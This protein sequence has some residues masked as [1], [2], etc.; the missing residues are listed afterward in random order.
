MA[1]RVKTFIQIASDMLAH[2]RA[3]QRRISDFNVGS[4][5][6]VMLEAPAAEID[7]LYQSYTRGLI[8][9]IPVAIYRSFDFELQEAVS[10]SGLVRFSAV[11]GHS[12]PVVIR[13]GFLVAAGG[14]Q[15][16]VAAEAVIPV[17][18]LTVDV[19]VV[20]RTK[21]VE[22][23]A[24][25]DTITSLVSS[26]VDLQGVTN[27][28]ALSN[29]RGMETDEERKLRF[30]EYVR[31]LARGTP[32]SCVYAARQARLVDSST[33]FIL[34]R[35]TRAE[36]QETPGHTD[37][38]IHNGAGNTSDALLKRATDL[39][40]GG[41]SDP[42]TGLPVAGYDAVGARLD[43]LK[44]AEIPV[45]ATLQVQVPTAARTEAMRAKIIA[46]VSGAIRAV[47][48][49]ESLLPIDLVNA[50]LALR[51]PVQG[52][53]VSAPVLAVACPIKAVLVPGTI[54]IVWI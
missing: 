47:R 34:E 4:V 42:I 27:P 51:A 21:G 49:G 16:Q 35:V 13:V 23:N 48:S 39:V 17:G 45:S 53:E 50:A 29:G 20:C 2:M 1:F 18:Q 38:W 40:L 54:T 46:A 12:E 44:M 10:A 14:L 24:Q 32:A 26:A 30:N 19:L 37:M 3:A 25:P 15:Y 8:E 33:G 31:T 36:L 52:A 11:P 22:G 6:R 9:A 41:W 5:N 7:E 43:V 28:A